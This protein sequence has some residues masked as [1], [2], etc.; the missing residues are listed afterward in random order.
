MKLGQGIHSFGSLGQMCHA[1]WHVLRRRGEEELPTIGSTSIVRPGLYDQRSQLY[2]R[3][4]FTRYI[5]RA[6]WRKRRTQQMREALPKLATYNWRWAE[7]IRLA[8]V[9]AA[10]EDVGLAKGNVPTHRGQSKKRAVRLLI[11][12][13]GGYEETA[14]R[15]EL[16]SAWE[17]LGVLWA[18]KSWT[19]GE[20][21][22]HK[23]G[24]EEAIENGAMDQRALAWAREKGF[25]GGD[26]D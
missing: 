19:D 3:P 20:G 5:D 1:Q 10:V 21:R 9:D 11:E 12:E 7:V 6:E 14:L 18:E 25:V 23:G 15:R 4:A 26:V 24:L 13:G 8:C 17:W 22:L 2:P 16:N